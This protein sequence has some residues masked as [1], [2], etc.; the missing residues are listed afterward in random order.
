[1]R[2]SFSAWA[3][4]SIAVRP[5]CPAVNS[6]ASLWAGRWCGNRPVFLLDEPL[7]NLDSRLRLEMRRELHLLHQRLRATMFYVTHDQEEALTLG[8]RVAVLDR[9]QIQQVDRPDVLYERP[10]NRFVAGFIGWPAMNLLDGVLLCENEPLTAGKRGGYAAAGRCP[11]SG[12]AAFRG[13]ARHVGAPARTP[14][15]GTRGRYQERAKPWKFAWWKRWDRS[16]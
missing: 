13:A 16:G 14:A 5:N 6:S 9:G 7:S 2:R 12:V 8:D 11:T 3:T 10:A 1:M 4:C 15:P